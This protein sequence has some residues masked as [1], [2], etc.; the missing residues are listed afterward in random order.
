MMSGILWIP[1]LQMCMLTFL[2]KAEIFSDWLI[3]G[4]RYDPCNY[5]PSMK[6]NAIQF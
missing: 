3:W 4:Q 2:I 1:D 6:D 5:P